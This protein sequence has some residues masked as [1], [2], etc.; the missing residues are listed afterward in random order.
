MS[1]I[2]QHIENAA[3]KH[4]IYKGKSYNDLSELYGFSSQAWRDKAKVHNWDAKREAWLEKKQEYESD[5]DQAVLAIEK[6]R[7]SIYKSV[8]DSESVLSVSDVKLLKQLDELEEASYGMA[9]KT[10]VAAEIFNA[11]IDFVQNKYQNGDLTLAE[12]M[13][14]AIY[15]FMQDYFEAKK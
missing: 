9:Y 3:E 7:S 5:L 15:E 11:L 13:H 4:Y 2:P 12:K 14:P 8:V 6:T 10:T 1:R